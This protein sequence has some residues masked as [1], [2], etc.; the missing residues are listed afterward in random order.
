MLHR[1]QASRPRP[2]KDGADSAPWVYTRSPAAGAGT[3]L[4]R[5]AQAASTAGAGHGLSLCVSASVTR[6]AGRVTESRRPT[7]VSAVTA[8]A[9]PVR[10]AKAAGRQTVPETLGGG[11]VTVPE[12]ILPSS[13]CFEASQKTLALCSRK[14]EA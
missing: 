2:S 14:L 10:E 8:L 6:H 3:A 5:T 11:R 4:P 9:L 13:P 7:R 1:P 12:H